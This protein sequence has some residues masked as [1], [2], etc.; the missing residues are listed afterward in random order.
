MAD[1]SLR[2]VGDQAAYGYRQL[3]GVGADGG[4]EMRSV[5]FAGVGV[6]L[7]IVMG[8][9]FASYNHQTATQPAKRV[10]VQTGTAVP[11]KSN[12]QAGKAVQVQASPSPSK[13]SPSTLSEP[14]QKQVAEA[15]TKQVAPVKQ[16]VVKT[17]PA[18]KLVATK[19]VAGRVSAALGQRSG[20]GA[21]GRRRH[22]GRERL[23]S[24]RWRRSHRR[25]APVGK[26]AAAVRPEQQAKPRETFVFWVEGDV[27]EANY[28]PSTGVIETYEGETFKVIEGA[29]A[30][31]FAELNDFP[32]AVHY[33][34]NQVGSCRLRLPNGS[35]FP[36]RQLNSFN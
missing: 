28:D 20:H 24:R 25:A 15:V 16:G 19:P 9:L 5:I 31:G 8:T 17:L 27:T 11:L 35:V 4:T 23:H 7:G 26:T 36:A 6:A 29:D 33:R 34:C 3:P 1:P 30:G 32:L 18:A 12:S 22:R 13:L 21:L 14:A 10:A 2:T